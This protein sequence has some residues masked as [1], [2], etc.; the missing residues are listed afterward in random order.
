[1]V[2]TENETV[3]EELKKW[4][5]QKLQTDEDTVEAY[6]QA[7]MFEPTRIVGK[8][9]DGTDD[10]EY[11]EDLPKTVFKYVEDFVHKRNVD[12]VITTGPPLLDCK[13]FGTVPNHKYLGF[14]K[15]ACSMCRDVVCRHCCVAR[16]ED[17]VERTLCLGC[18]QKQKLVGSTKFCFKRKSFSEPVSIFP[19]PK[20]VGEKANPTST[21]TPSKGIG[22]D[23]YNKSFVAS[24][25]ESEKFGLMLGTQTYSPERF[26][27]LSV[28]TAVGFNVIP[29]TLCFDSPR[30]QSK[31]N[32][33][34]NGGS[35]KMSRLIKVKPGLPDV[36]IKRRTGFKSEAAMLSFVSVVCNGDF[37]L[38][39]YA[40][41]TLTWYEEWIFYFEFIWGKS[42]SRWEDA[43]SEAHFNLIAKNLRKI[44]DR[45]LNIVLAC[46]QK[47]PTY[48]YYNEDKMFTD[49]KWILKYG[50]SRVIMW[51]DTNVNFTFMPSTAHN[52]RLTYS[53]YYG[54]NC[55][56]GGVH[57]QF[58][59]WMGVY[60]LWNGGVSDSE[61]LC[62]DDGPDG[63]I[64]ARQE[65]F[66]RCDLVNGDVKEVN[67]ILDKGYRVV[68]A[69]IRYSQKVT[70]PIFASLLR[71]F[72]GTEGLCIAEIASDRSGN[73]RAVRCVKQ[74]G[75]ISR[76]IDR[77]QSFERMNNVWKAFSFQCNFMFKPVL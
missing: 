17:N 53:S 57:L 66:Q 72:R 50:D 36:E 43:Q 58:C 13:G 63:G 40:P 70:Q 23:R 60:D 41:S 1:M 29:R 9:E 68:Q 59:G 37:N 46:R 77:N 48:A 33:T 16:R 38:I 34:P 75:Y 10:Y 26:N 52:Q 67:N 7:L 56:K 44:F 39:E 22:V 4:Y 28:P 32:D 5:A 30:K 73:E 69:M 19:V 49:N 35:D 27:N 18:Y 20:N 24:L 55:A 11:L 21:V 12:C 76:G 62:S 8:E 42:L 61:Y 54:G 6:I 65:K 47:W 45:K 51:D 3:T 31:L 14:L 2:R 15:Q 74:S 25:H 71:N 64:L